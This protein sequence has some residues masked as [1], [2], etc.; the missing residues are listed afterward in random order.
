[1]DGSYTVH[2]RTVTSPTSHELME[3]VEF[4]QLNVRIIAEQLTRIDSVSHIQENIVDVTYYHTIPAAFLLLLILLHTYLY[5]LSTCKRSKLLSSYTH[6]N[7]KL[8]GQTIRLYLHPINYH[9]FLFQ[10]K[11]INK[12]LGC[13]HTGMVSVC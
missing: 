13:S 3:V 8:S 10:L 1:M 11:T 6:C 12:S 4:S 9:H 5:K 7:A 2:G